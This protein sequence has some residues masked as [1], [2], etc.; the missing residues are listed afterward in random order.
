MLAI[1][2]AAGFLAQQEAP[3]VIRRGDDAH[4]RTSGQ[5]RRFFYD[6]QIDEFERA[7]ERL[8]KPGKTRAKRAAAV[9]A[10]FEPINLPSIAP[11]SVAT[12]LRSAVARFKSADIDAAEL[13]ELVMIQAE[14][15]RRHVR[16]RNDE[17]AIML[18]LS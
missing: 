16:R 8:A 14:T 17:A 1:W 6:K 11:P 3:A 12:E 7:A 9:V 10:A 5:S 4:F 18:L 15:M 2:L 13:R